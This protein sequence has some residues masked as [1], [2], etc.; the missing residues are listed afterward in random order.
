LCEPLPEDWRAAVDRFVDDVRET[1]GLVIAPHSVADIEALIRSR[2]GGTGVFAAIG[3]APQHKPDTAA[4]ARPS[5]PP[6]YK[7]AAPE[8]ILAG[9]TAEARRYAAPQAAQEAA[10][11]PVADTVPG[12]QP[13]PQV[14]ARARMHQAW[15]GAEDTLFERQLAAIGKLL[16]DLG[17]KLDAA[18]LDEVV[19]VDEYVD[20]IAGHIWDYND[21][22]ESAR[23]AWLRGNLSTEAIGR[24]NRISS[25]AQF[26]LPAFVDDQQFERAN[27]QLTQINRRLGARAATLGRF[28]TGL[29]VADATVTAA[30]IAVGGGIAIDV[31]KT[32]GKW[33]VVRLA[34]A[35][36]AGIAADKAAAA[37]LRA[38]GASQ[39]TIRRRPFGCARGHAYT[40]AP[41]QR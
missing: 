26:G 27:R 16:A 32:G 2:A 10:L 11:R 37:G 34:V 35:A 30:G 18:K 28:A 21:S 8:D 17:A 29:R 25:P 19:D 41:P 15:R 14:P 36:G 1:I 38:A 20:Q 3:P 39:E 22:L 5:L 12:R 23:D 24:L 6:G 9:F 40:T 13:A 33:A 4:D 7:P 31:F